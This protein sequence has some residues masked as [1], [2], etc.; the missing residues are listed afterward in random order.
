M[1]RGLMLA[2]ALV[3]LTLIV[4]LPFGLALWDSV[5]A[6]DY[7][8]PS[9]VHSWTGPESYHELVHDSGFRASLGRSLVFALAAAGLETVLGLGLG[10]A[11]T[12]LGP[13]ARL[14]AQQILLIPVFVAPATVGLIWYLLLHPDFGALTWIIGLARPLLVSPGTT[15]LTLIAVDLWQWTPFVALLVL[16]ALSRIWPELE[17][18]ATLD[19]LGWVRRFVAVQAPSIKVVLGVAGI[20]RFLEAFKLYDTVKILT[21]GGPGTATEMVSLW[22]TKTTFDQTRLGYGAAATL[23]LDYLVIAVATL[24]FALIASKLPRQR[25]EA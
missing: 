18:A 6:M 1:Q 21:G 20:L 5:H 12:H 17:Q 23:V 19:R 14:L 7:T 15:F 8:D 11:L 22:I 24:L 13:R 16:V 25:A 3:L 4:L 9:G 10:L 2:P